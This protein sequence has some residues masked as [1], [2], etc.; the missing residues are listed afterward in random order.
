MITQKIAREIGLDEAYGGLLPGDKLSKLESILENKSGS[1]AFVGDGINDAPSLVRADIGITMG[2]IGSDAAIEASDVVIMD[3]DP[4]KIAVS[5][6]M[7]RKCM[8]IIR[9]NI[10]ITLLVKFGFLGLA[11]VGLV[12]MWFAIIADVGVMIVAVLNS[13]RALKY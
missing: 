13:A 8:R 4:E 12:N 9:Q 11:A 7:S 5:I 10:A 1:V 6:E 3:D 2:A